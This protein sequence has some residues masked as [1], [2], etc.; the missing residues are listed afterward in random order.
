MS[1]PCALRILKSVKIVSHDAWRM[2]QQYGTM[3]LPLEPEELP[4]EPLLNESTER[5]GVAQKEDRLIA[6]DPRNSF[7]AIYVCKHCGLLYMDEDRV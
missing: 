6:V 5:W 2:N 1:K 7:D 4:H 3:Y